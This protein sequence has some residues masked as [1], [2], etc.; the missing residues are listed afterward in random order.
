MSVTLVDRKK[1]GLIPYIQ[2]KAGVNFERIGAPQP[3]QM[4]QIAGMPASR[5]K[6]SCKSVPQ[7]EQ[8][9]SG[10]PC[11]D[12]KGPSC[13]PCQ[14]GATWPEVASRVNLLPAALAPLSPCKGVFHM[15]HATCRRAGAGDAEGAG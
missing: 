10:S 9:E 7:S 2:K 15:R 8:S 6:T 12:T 4:A 3:A 14:H 11:A 1:E 13:P 5:F